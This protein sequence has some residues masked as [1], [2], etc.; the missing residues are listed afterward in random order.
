[1]TP[2]TLASIDLSRIG[3][4]E[5]D[6]A[7]AR[8]LDRALATLGF[9]TIRGHGVPPERFDGAYSIARRFFGLPEDVKRRFVPDRPGLFR[10]Y[11]P[12]GSH[13]SAVGS[14]KADG[15]RAPGDLGETYMISRVDG[16]DDP[17]YHNESFG[18]TYAP[19][20]WPDVPGLR[21]EMEAYY[22]TMERLALRLMELAAIGLDLDES[23]FVGKLRR[24]CST[25][26]LINYPP[27]AAEPV[28]GQLRRGEHTDNGVLTLLHQRTDGPPGLQVKRK[29]GEWV[30]IRTAPGEIILNIGDLLAR[31]TNDR[32]VSTPHRVVLPEGEWQLVE[33]LSLAY[34]QKTDF[35]AVIEVASTC[36][37]PG[38]TPRYEPIVA[39]E[40]MRAKMLRSRGQAA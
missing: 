4:A 35:D 16:L 38:E 2:I 15:A 17:Y 20:L 40:W 1:M 25:C 30:D 9:A 18:L 21:E 19:N 5:E 22:R 10:G 8:E 29:D 12:V 28:P 31:W 13:R 14:H 34:F 37:K 26:T 39:G 6:R 33:R 27:L 3:S 32:W 24:H 11:S 36:L 23:F 7:A